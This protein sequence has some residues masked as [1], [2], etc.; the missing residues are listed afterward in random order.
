MSTF[1][2]SPAEATISSETTMKAN[3]KTIQDILLRNLRRKGVT[4]PSIPLLFKDLERSFSMN[5][6]MEYSELNDRL[7]LLGW[8]DVEVDY[9]TCELARAAFSV[10]D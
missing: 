7:H 2:G 3:V 6:S 1:V 10:S 5:P 9:R 4:Q 8:V